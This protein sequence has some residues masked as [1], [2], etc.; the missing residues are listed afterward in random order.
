[1]SSG[2]I[3]LQRPY[4]SFS[5][6][7]FLILRQETTAAAVVLSFLMKAHQML[8]LKHYCSCF[9]ENGVQVELKAE[10]LDSARVEDMVKEY[11]NNADKVK[12]TI[13]LHEKAMATS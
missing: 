7:L 9:I 10:S 1:M 11:F 2:V 3:L 13:V 6:P 5:S 4:I 8:L 12:R